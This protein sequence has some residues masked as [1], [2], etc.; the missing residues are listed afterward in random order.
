[1]D[2]IDNLQNAIKEF[3]QETKKVHN[4]QILG[5]KI[6]GLIKAVSENKK[7]LDTSIHH[8][9]EACNALQDASSKFTE[10]VKSLSK[11]IEAAENARKLHFDRLQDLL[12]KDDKLRNDSHSAIVSEQKKYFLKLTETLKQ[13]EQLR[14]EYYLSLKN[15]LEAIVKEFQTSVEGE[16]S[17]AVNHY[18]DVGAEEYAAR[19]KQYKEMQSLLDN[20][21]KERGNYYQKL[22]KQVFDI[23][24][25]LRGAIS[26]AFNDSLNK[27]LEVLDARFNKQNELLQSLI[28]NID[29]YIQQ[30]DNQHKEFM[31]EVHNGFTNGNLNLLKN[32]SVVEE[33]VSSKLNLIDT[34]LKS[35]LI[36]HK[37]DID[38]NITKLDND[39][40]SCFG[41]QNS[42]IQKHISSVSSGSDQIIIN[43]MSAKNE[44]LAERICRLEAFAKYGLISSG[45]IIILLIALMFFK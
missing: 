41:V 6:A 35:N 3:Q 27:E 45:L 12:A 44:I 2:P 19:D 13:E 40:Q 1:M 42:S 14:Q 22:D 25:K 7:I 30:S 34:E 28:D 36:S 24:P 18:Q 32:I 43:E 39:V 21:S 38:S 31:I 29:S 16:L 20:E 23:I 8:T 11:D 33:T 17:K 5:E 9:D 15:G 10:N 4:I 37:Q 26:D